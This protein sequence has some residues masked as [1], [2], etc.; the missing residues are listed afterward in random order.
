MKA[1]IY[2]IEIVKAVPKAGKLVI[3]DIDYCAGWDDKLNMGVSCVCAYDEEEKRPRIFFEDNKEEFEDLFMRRGILVGFNNRR[4]DNV[5]LAQSGWIKDVS[6]AFGVVYDIL[7]LIWV[8]LGFDPDKFTS[9]THA[10]YG[11]D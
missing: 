1:L 8:N 2:D 6:S 7:E 4:F 10:G 3:S 5:V 11:L 9:E